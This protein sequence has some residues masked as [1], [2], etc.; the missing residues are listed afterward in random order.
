MDVAFIEPVFLDFTGH[1]LL[2]KQDMAVG[3]VRV[4]QGSDT[5]RFQLVLGAA[6]ESAKGGVAM[7]GA[8]VERDEGHADRGRL[9]REF[10][11]F[12]AD[13]TAEQTCRVGGVGV[14]CHGDLGVTEV[15]SSIAVARLGAT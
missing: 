8:A 14:V 7:D 10:I 6:E 3:V 2:V 11:E 15:R 12:L 1:E 4:G 9:K 5:D 13:G